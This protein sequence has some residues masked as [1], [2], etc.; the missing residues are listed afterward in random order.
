[1]RVVF[2][3]DVF[4]RNM[5]YME[6]IFPKYL[7]RLGVEVHVIAMDLLPYYWMEKFSETYGGFSE[8]LPP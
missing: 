3:S 6:N 8:Q 7:A 1:M 5:G 4:A 2:L